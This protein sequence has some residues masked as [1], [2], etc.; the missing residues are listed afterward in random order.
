MGG[1]VKKYVTGISYTSFSLGDFITWTQ[2]PI[3]GLLSTARVLIQ[4]SLTMT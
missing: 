1:S 2:T 3:Y 4:S